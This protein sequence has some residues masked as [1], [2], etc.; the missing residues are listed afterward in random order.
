MSQRGALN[1]AG[2]YITCFAQGGLHFTAG[3]ESGSR[4]MGMLDR[5]KPRAFVICSGI[6]CYR[7]CGEDVLHS[8]GKGLGSWSSQPGVGSE[9]L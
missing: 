3:S 7:V 5:G 1:R 4:P 9:W 2:P 6:R 8:R